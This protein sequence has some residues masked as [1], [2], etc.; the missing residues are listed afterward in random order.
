MRFR[1]LEHLFPLRDIYELVHFEVTETTCVGR[2]N[3][4][5]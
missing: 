3:Q 1:R 4:V 5:F 2:L